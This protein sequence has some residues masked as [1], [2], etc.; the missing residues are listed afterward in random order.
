MDQMGYLL[1]GL[2]VLGITVNEVLRKV[3]KTSRKFPSCWKCG[4]HMVQT[5]VPNVLPDAVIRYLEEYQLTT[6]VVSRYV[7]LRGCYR[8]WY[9]PPFG[10]IE[11]AFF[12]KEEM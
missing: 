2:A 9:V 10:Q 8:L 3:E 11:K 7:C 4:K 5:P 1:G 6:T 12:L